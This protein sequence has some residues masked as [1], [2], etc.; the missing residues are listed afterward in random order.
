[1]SPVIELS[2]LTFRR[3]Q[4]VAVP[5]VDTPETVIIRALD[6]LRNASSPSQNNLGVGETRKLPPGARKLDPDN[7]GSLTHTKV[8]LGRFDVLVA[9][10]WNDLLIQAHAKTKQ[11]L[12]TFEELKRASSSAIVEGERTDSGFHFQAE[13]GFSIQY[14]DANKAWEQILFLAKRLGVAVEVQFR[15]REKDGAR[16]PGEFGVLRWAPNDMATARV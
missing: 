4:E 8:M 16:F 5:F 9:D 15:W 10:K 6:A 1:M 11:I 14:V 3:L 12:G 13:S 2:D 7:P